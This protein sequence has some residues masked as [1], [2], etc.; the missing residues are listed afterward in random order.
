MTGSVAQWIDRTF[1]PSFAHNW[2]DALLR[3]RILARLSPEQCIL[4]LGAGGGVVTQMNF[5][6]LVTKTCGVDLDP[7]VCENPMLDEG[8]VADAGRVPYG[9]SMFDIVFADNVLEHLDEPAQVFAE[10]RRVLKPGGRFLFKTPN[11]THYMPLIAQCTPHW[12]HGFINRLR[13]RSVIDTF[14]TRYRT[15]DVATLRRLA[16]ETCFDVERI[17]LIEG[18]PEYLRMLWPAYLVG[19]VYE[20]LVNSTEILAMFRVLC[21]GEFKKPA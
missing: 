1:Y 13:G 8:R 18:R 15:N 5:R 21:I 6:G 7:R 14:P 9:D 11:R 12:F 19:L 20:R 4:D 10:V 2:D 3:E 17:E 16:S